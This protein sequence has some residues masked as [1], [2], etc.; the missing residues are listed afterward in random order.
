MQVKSL[1]LIKD[2]PIFLTTGRMHMYANTCEID[3]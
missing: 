2:Q 3:A 1:Q